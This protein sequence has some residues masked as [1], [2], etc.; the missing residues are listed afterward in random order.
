LLNSPLDGQQ[1]EPAPTEPANVQGFQARQSDWE[2]AREYPQGLKGDAILLEARIVA[3]A[4]VVEAMSS[5]RP[6]RPGLGIEIALAEI[7]RGRGIAYDPNI[8]DI[9]LKLFREKGYVIPG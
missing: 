7:E 1:V 9:C 5:H 3:V 6:Y 4:D 8:V 2:L